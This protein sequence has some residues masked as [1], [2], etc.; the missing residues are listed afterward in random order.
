MVR[1]N[2]ISCVMARNVSKTGLKI[3]IYFGSR[4]CA[5]SM[6]GRYANLTLRRFYTNVT[7]PRRDHLSIVVK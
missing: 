5:T 1:N 6:R 3:E 4:H 7:V 2:Y